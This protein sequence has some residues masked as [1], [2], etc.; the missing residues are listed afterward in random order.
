M[1]LSLNG[2]KESSAPY[3]SWPKQN[4]PCESQNGPDV[5]ASNARPRGES[6]GS[7]HRRSRKRKRSAFWWRKN[8]PRT[9]G[10][11]RR[12]FARFEKSRKVEVVRDANLS[13]YFETDLFTNA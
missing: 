2:V 9:D 13:L 6:D 4:A 8:P 11:K 7:W 10:D 1:S 3:A 5:M 12:S